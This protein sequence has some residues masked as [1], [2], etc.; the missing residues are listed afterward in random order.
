[1]KQKL[2]FLLLFLSI[3]LSYVAQ[4][5]KIDS[6]KL[7]LSTSKIDTSIIKN[8]C[9][10]AT[11]AVESNPTEFKP[12]IDKL[13][14]ESKKQKFYYGE[15]KSY[16]I[17]GIYF[18][19]ISQYDSAIISYNKA[20][21]I[22][23]KHNL[24]TIKASALNNLGLIYWNIGNYDKAI[25]NYFL[26]LKQ[27]EI[28]HSEKNIA[29]VTNNIGLVYNDMLNFNQAI[30]YFN[31]ALNIYTNNNDLYGIGSVHTNLGISYFTLKDYSK[32]KQHID[33]SIVIKRKIEDDYGL[34]VSLI[35]LSDIE[36][37]KR[38]FVKAKQT[39]TEAETLLRKTGNKSMLL[40]VYD[41][42]SILA[43]RILNYKEALAYD[44]K[45]VQIS[46]EIGSLRK[47]YL[48]LGNT[49]LIYY[50]LKDFK[51]AYDYLNAATLISDSVL[52]IEN[53]ESINEMK[54]KF[55]TEKKEAENKLLTQQNNIKSLENE[56]NRKTIFILIGAISTIVLI[57]LWQL[58]LVRVKKQKR[59]LETEKKLQLDRE[60]ISRDLHDNIG[61]QLSYVMF[62]LEGKEEQSSDERKEK[63]H[64]LANA[65]RNVTSNLR[66]TIW[67][68]NQEELSAQDISDKLKVYARNMFNYSNTKI[69][70]D[71]NISN[72]D[73]M[74]PTVALHIF[75]ISQEIINNVFKHAMAT[76]VS[77][78]VTKKEKLMITI[79]DNGIGF[80]KEQ[81]QH[82]SYGLSNLINRAQEIN[83]TLN[84]SSEINKGTIITLV[85]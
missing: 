67:A 13:I 77:I 65:L 9:R 54:E 40:T 38:E 80:S 76:E 60:R 69:T 21:E 51:N 46:K 10:I 75:R 41:N 12:F 70:F 78:S 48:T 74:E 64:T 20:Y 3:T 34:A 24:S 85:V 50:E 45:S 25:K 66:E 5:K 16:N 55:E 29:N 4:L 27:F 82:E 18:D 56:T 2:V 39:L 61:G 6:L 1:M 53:F 14:I 49:A 63:S 32:A 73:A 59:L 35:H 23:T 47:Q 58:S 83:G 11:S 17:K 44:L 71:E 42:L 81:Q 57:I 19:I 84:I 79:A 36:I 68:L 31:K 37:F 7:L 28:N 43:K 8:A 62:S 33:T 15:A 72:G 26:A 22:A 30:I 52:N